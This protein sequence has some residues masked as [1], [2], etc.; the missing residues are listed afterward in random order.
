[1]KRLNR[2][3]LPIIIWNLLFFPGFAHGWPRALLMVR[4][5][6]Q[7]LDVS[8]EYDGRKSSGGGGENLHFQE[9]RLEESYHFDTAYAVY[10]PRVLVGR[11]GVDLGVNQDFFSG[12]EEDSGDDYGTLLEYDLN[13]TFF[14]RRACP[15]NF[16]SRR[17]M[18][19]VM[20]KYARNYDLDSDNYGLNL[21][22]RN[23]WLP[24]HLGYH[25]T[26]DET[27]GLELDRR[28]Q[29]D[30][31]TMSAAHVYRNISS[32]QFSFYHSDDETDYGGVENAEDRKTD[33]YDLA[34]ILTWGRYARRSTLSSSYRYRDESGTTPIS[35]SSWRESLGW[36][37]GRALRW[38]VDYENNRDE[39]LDTTRKEQVVRTWLE[40]HLYESLT[41]RL[42]YE[43]RTIDLDDSGE[44]YYDGGINLAYS[45]LLPADSRVDIAYDFSYGE[46]DRDGDANQRFILG[47]SVVMA[48]AGTNYLAYHHVDAA[49]IIVRSADRLI[50]YL[51]GVDYTV[52]QVGTRTGLELTAGSLINPGDRVSVDYVYLVDSGITFSSTSHQA[53]ASLTLF[54]RRYRLYGNLYIMD[55]KLLDSDE[56]LENDLLLSDVTSWTL[57]AQSYRGYSVYGVEYMNYDATTDVWQSLEGYWRYSRYFSSHYLMVTLRDRVTSYDANEVSDASSSEEENVVTAG[58]AYRKRLPYRA[59]AGFSANYLNQSGRSND[60]ETLDVSADYRMHFGLLELELEASQEWEWQNGRTERDDRL[61]LT[62]RRRL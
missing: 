14:D 16:F 32:S 17:E 30:T 31:V 55:Q 23:P 26:D 29:I 18:S 49:S 45:K 36:Q 10:H 33:E 1:M 37:L 39:P 6:H 48:A 61:M 20:R 19:Q 9:H 59:L 40:H 11:V 27:D 43:Q 62:F 53:T 5:F 54:S 57:G 13:G 21:Y 52:T 41:T 4:D 47:E 42:R 8:Y 34:N 35:T 25:H 22:W 56:N 60:R 51:E 50:Q 38:N 44:D 28:Q 46:T 3:L 7:W 12:S 15:I 2:V 58:L 24:L